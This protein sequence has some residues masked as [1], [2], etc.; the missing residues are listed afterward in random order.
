MPKIIKKAVAMSDLH[1]GQEESILNP[2]FFPRSNLKGLAGQINSLGK[3]D[4]LIILGDFMDFSLA[5]LREAYKN[6]RD[7][8]SI[9]GKL[10]NIDEIVYIPGNHDHH[11]WLE[12]V[13]AEEVI[14]KVRQGRVPA[15][16]DNYVENLVDRS[17]GG[18]HKELFLC[19]LLP[20]RN[21]G[22][23][24]KLK[25]K[26]PHHL[27]S[28]GEG[29]RSYL[30]THGHY[31]ED[32]FKPVNLLIEPGFLAELEA[33]NCLWLEGLWYHMGQSGRFG[34]L[35]EKVFEDLR[36][37]KIETPSSLIAKAVSL[38]ETKY[39]IFWLKVPLIKKLTNWYVRG[40]L[41]AFGLK[42]RADLAGSP[43][44]EEQKLKIQDYIEKFVLSR[45]NP[46]QNRKQ[47]P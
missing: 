24:V 30:F 13:E 20:L 38:V 12:L 8:F 5:T 7:F 27:R 40:R 25:V 43:I 14:D 26:Y 31:L 34:Q 22:T 1:L 46:A 11:L 37:G 9:V 19:S 23:K 39:K 16:I 36:E 32:V 2:V 41:R 44:D 42:K 6:A 35:I 15:E 10:D 21:D 29:K 28:F 3:I 4:E 18:G 45:Y 47:I 17:F 33:F